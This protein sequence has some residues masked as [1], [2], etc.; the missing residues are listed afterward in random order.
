MD[1]IGWQI[2]V[3]IFKIRFVC[4]DAPFFL[5]KIYYRSSRG[6]AIQE[7]KATDTIEK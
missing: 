3:L 6:V 2:Q 7:E 5:D 4:L 1:L